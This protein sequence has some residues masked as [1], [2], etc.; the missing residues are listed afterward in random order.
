MPQMPW[1]NNMYASVMPNI[2]SSFYA[3]KQVTNPIFHRPT[4]IVKVDLNPS[5]YVVQ[6]GVKN[7]KKAHRHQ[8]SFYSRTCDECTMELH[9]ILSEKQLGDIF[10][11]PLNQHSQD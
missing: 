5:D 7:R 4:P 8:V 10:N 11:K 3:T 9:F 1:M 6:I 2:E